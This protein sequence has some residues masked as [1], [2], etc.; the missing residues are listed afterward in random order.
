MAGKQNIPMSDL[1]NMVQ[2]Y[3]MLHN[4]RVACLRIRIWQNA[5]NSAKATPD[6]PCTL[7]AEV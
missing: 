3:Y 5:C 6:L 7:E 1:S 4:L 2:P